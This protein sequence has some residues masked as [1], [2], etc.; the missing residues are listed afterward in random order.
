MHRL[1][2]WGV[3]LALA[4][5]ADIPQPRA[6]EYPSR[7]IRW[8]IG[9]PP[10]SA[11]DITARL[12]GNEISKTL[13][14]QVVIEARPGAGSSL[15]G[16]VV[17]RAAPDGYTL[18]MGT[19]S[20]VTNS[21][22]QTNLRFDFIKDFAPILNLT[23]MPLILVAHP[24]VPA[25][26]VQELI[27]LAKAKP[28]ELA[29]GSVGAGTVGHLGMEL[30][31]QRTGTK[32]V[33]VPYPGS[34]QQSTDLVAGRISMALVVG[35]TVL[36]HVRAGRLKMLATCSSQ[37]LAP[38][39][40]LVSESLVPGFDCAVWFGMVAPAGT[41]RPIIDKL[42]AAAN[43]ALKVEEVHNKFKA[44]DFEPLGGDP[45]TFAKQIVSDTAKWMDAAKA[46]GLRN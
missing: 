45:D 40:P 44:G 24:S 31:A 12:V 33:H 3:A 28:G 46:A 26:N 32:F 17:A 4:A 22:V 6:D 37:R 36:P 13:G 41:P 19:L 20:N 35:S 8:I 11:A 21:A 18:Y 39:V 14:Q 23:G 34:P 38:D 25:N 7:P 9:F 27:A 42:A 5:L 16:E 43:A 29:Y 1:A 10:G 2:A 15:A 30:I